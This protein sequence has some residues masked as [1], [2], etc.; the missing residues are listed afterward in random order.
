MRLEDRMHYRPHV[1][2]AEHL[3]INKIESEPTT[4]LCTSLY[5]ASARTRRA[6]VRSQLR[7]LARHLLWTRGGTAN[8]QAGA[9]RR[10]RGHGLA[11]QPLDQKM[12]GETAFLDD[13]L[14]NR[15]QRRAGPRGHRPVVVA[16]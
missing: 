16:D 4:I 10:R 8:H 1:W 11:L 5:L 12:R 14:A 7:T 13:R 6:R 9:E 15:G 2:K 3:P